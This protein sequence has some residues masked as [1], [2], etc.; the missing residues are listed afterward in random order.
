MLDSHVVSH[1]IPTFQQGMGAMCAGDASTWEEWDVR[2]SLFDN[3]VSP[4]LESNL[5]YMFKKFGFFIPDAEYLRDPEGL[6]KYLV[7]PPPPLPARA[8]SPPF[9][10]ALAA[11]RY[12]V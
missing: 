2:R 3:H 11:T 9:L 7:P 4:D 1:H 5:D 6:I 12:A 10:A 8:T